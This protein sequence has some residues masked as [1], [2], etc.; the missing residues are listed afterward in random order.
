MGGYGSGRWGWHTKKALTDDMR[1]LDVRK[2]H[3]A[4]CLLSGAH[5]WQWLENGEQV[6][7]IGF[8]AKPGR[9]V[10]KYNAGTGGKRQSYEY[11]VFLDW[12]ECNYGGRRPWFLCPNCGRRVAK[13]YGG[14]HFLCR[15]CHGLAYWT[16]RQDK[17]YRALYHADK[18][19]ARL[20]W[21]R[22]EPGDGWRKP[23]GMHWKTFD[24]LSALVDAWEGVADY[25][26][27]GRM[28]AMLSR[29]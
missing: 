28:Q 4:G 6:A 23:R 29:H 7:S 21:V 13:L 18:L 19:R 20:G 27:M 26:H 5:L 3:K 8:E 2:I 16:Q 9:L 17:A 22:G 25:C 15:K 24:R 12:T 14:T 10:L 1:A 11:P